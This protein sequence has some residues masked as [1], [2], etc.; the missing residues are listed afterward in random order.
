MYMYI[1]TWL[2]HI[3]WPSLLNCLPQGSSLV[4]ANNPSSQLRL[5]IL[6]SFGLAFTDWMKW[7]LHWWH[8]AYDAKV[9]MA[10]HT[11]VVCSI[12]HHNIS[13]LQ[14]NFERFL[15]CGKPTLF[16]ICFVNV[17][18]QWFRIP[19]HVYIIYASCYYEAI[20]RYALHYNVTCPPPSTMEIRN[21]F[22]QI[23]PDSDV[24]S[25][26]SPKLQSVIT[27]WDI[28]A[29][30]TRILVNRRYVR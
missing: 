27:L 2:S 5:E 29:P 26:S 14:L 20:K 24:G 21:F 3:Q 30:L 10:A 4:G 7:I 17:C 11:N 13:L 23:S 8:V 9:I 1:P 28:R 12:A 6:V 22:S 15:Q 19:L 16:L 25:E 18:M